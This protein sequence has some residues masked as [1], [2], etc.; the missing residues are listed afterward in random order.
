MKKTLLLAVV[1]MMMLAVPFRVNAQ[2]PTYAYYLAPGYSFN[3]HSM[4]TFPD[5]IFEFNPS[6][7]F[8]Q[9]VST[10]LHFGWGHEYEFM[11]GLD[12]TG[13]PMYARLSTLDVG[14]NAAFC[15]PPA[16]SKL[17]AGPFIGGSVSRAFVRGTD[18][19]VATT[20]AV[21]GQINFNFGDATKT[22]IG[23]YVKGGINKPFNIDTDRNAVAS[24]AHVGIRLRVMSD[25]G[26]SY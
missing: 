25:G 16:R 18:R 3:Q 20:V 7:E 9:Y 13:S 4:L 15:I 23:L 1:V 2:G 8:A 5:I 12:S 17:F 6:I 24:E 11:N 22:G 26:S 10:G 14:F 19:G 21:Y